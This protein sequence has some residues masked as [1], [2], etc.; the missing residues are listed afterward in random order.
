[1]NFNEVH[2]FFKSKEVTKLLTDSYAKGYIKLE[3][4]HIMFN[5]ADMHAYFWIASDRCFAVFNCVKQALHF[6]DDVINDRFDLHTLTT[7]Q[8]MRL[9]T[10]MVKQYEYTSLLG[11][12]KYYY[13]D[14]S[15]KETVYVLPEYFAFERVSLYY[16]ADLTADDSYEILV[17]FIEMAKFY[18]QLEK[19]A[20][21]FYNKIKQVYSERN[22]ITALS[23]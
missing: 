2:D 8:F 17:D 6:I 14:S 15:A 11:K 12:I 21:V 18:K 7:G 3:F 13:D 4:F 20:N 1:M 9:Y 23:K 16:T 19:C 5:D 22:M 10:V